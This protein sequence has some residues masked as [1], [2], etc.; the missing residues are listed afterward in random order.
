MD[1]TVTTLTPSL[2]TSYAE[3]YLRKNEKNKPKFWLNN[4]E[5]LNCEEKGH[6]FRYCSYPI[7][8]FGIIAY[9]QKKVPPGLNIDPQRKYLLIQRKDTIG[10]LDLVRG[11]YSDPYKLESIKLLIEETTDHDKYKLLHCTFNDIW[12][13]LWTNKKSNSFTTER[14]Y[15]QKKFKKL[16]INNL[17]EGV[18]S[19]SND[20]DYGIPKGRKMKNETFLDCAIREFTEETGYNRDE[21][22]IRNVEPLTEVFYGSNTIAYKHTYFV[23]EVIT[24]RQPFLDPNNICQIEEIKNVRWVS[25]KESVNLFKYHQHKRSI[26]YKIDRTLDNLI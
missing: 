17:I 5:C 6:T 10:L 23:V 25:F 21:I 19:R 20:T 4:V 2:T 1:K 14:S 8:S 12:D 16:D 9:K 3:Q 11:K 22:V 15:A 7:N 13:Y 24:D 26:M 18:Y